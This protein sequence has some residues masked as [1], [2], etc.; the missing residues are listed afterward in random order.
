MHLF[1]ISGK[2][3]LPE[4]TVPVTLSKTKEARSRCVIFDS[5]PSGDMFDTKDGKHDKMRNNSPNEQNDSDAND[6]ELSN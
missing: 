5:L 6:L 2:I 3:S 4:T 1:G